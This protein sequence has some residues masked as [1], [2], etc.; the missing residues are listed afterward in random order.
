LV[1]CRK[2]IA[3][4]FSRPPNWWG[5]RLARVVE[6]EHRGDGVDAQ[7]VHVELLDP[8]QRVGDEE[9]AHLV[10]AVVEDQRAP[11]L[12]LAAAGIGV[13]VQGLAVEAGERERVAREVPGHPVHDHADARAVQAVDQIAQVVG[14]AEPARGGVVAGHLVA[15]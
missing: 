8:V 15:P 6:V 4:R 11:V 2:R 12:V 5:S 1:S 13:L 7:P 14:G 9:V 3:S 10:A